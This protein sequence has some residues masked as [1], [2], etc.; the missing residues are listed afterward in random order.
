MYKKWT[1]DEIEKVIDGLALKWSFP[2]NIPVE[3]STRAKKRLGAFF[4]KNINNKIEPIKF[5][6]SY[7]LLS[8]K[9][10]EEI[11]KEVIIHEYIHYYCNVKYNRNNGHNNI[12]KEM[13]I[14]NNISPK[15]T[16][17]VESFDKS[18]K[19]K[20]YCS[21]CDKVVCLHMRKDAAERKI[22]KYIS[23][24]CKAKLRYDLYI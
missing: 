22:K 9:Y 19:Y 24:C 4:Y 3:V 16:L 17:R 10:S 11:V 21:K 1:V 12:F 20:I 2:C 15:A 7:N 14:K 6:F 13:C 8:G 23:R 5:V 18:Y